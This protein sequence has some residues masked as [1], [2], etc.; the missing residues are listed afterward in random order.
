MT[1]LPP[2]TEFI[3][4]N[5]LRV[6]TD[7]RG[8][9]GVQWGA[10]RSGGWIFHDPDE[11]RALQE[12]FHAHTPAATSA[13]KRGPWQIYDVDG[14]DGTRVNIYYDAPEQNTLQAMEVPV[15]A[16]PQLFSLLGS[17]LRAGPRM[18]E[19]HTD[20]TPTEATR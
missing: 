12:F 7:V 14:S 3:A 11:T 2:S 5:G 17:F 8:A 1:A 19:D 9:V 6:S 10:P 15:V 16:L 20:A 4:S 13:H 18:N